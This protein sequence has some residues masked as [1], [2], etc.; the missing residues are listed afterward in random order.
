M[1]RTMWLSAFCALIAFAGFACEP[2]QGEPQAPITVRASIHGSGQSGILVVAVTTQAEGPHALVELSLPK[3]VRLVG[4]EGKAEADL[5][6]GKT[7]H[8][9]FPIKTDK[10]GAY[11]IGVKVM[12]GDESYRF[13]KSISVAWVAQ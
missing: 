11:V 10:P 8:F 9:R 6:P 5:E 7:V 1:K 12:A 13:G 3:G 4:K 2:E